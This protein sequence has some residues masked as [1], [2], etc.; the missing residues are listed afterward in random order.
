[1]LVPL[2]TYYIFIQYSSCFFLCCLFC[3]E[4]ASYEHPSNYFTKVLH[5]LF[6][7]LEKMNIFYEKHG[8][9]KK[10]KPCYSNEEKKNHFLHSNRILSNF[11]PSGIPLKMNGNNGYSWGTPVAC[12]R[13]C[14]AYQCYSRFTSCKFILDLKIKQT[15]SVMANQSN[16]D[17]PRKNF[18]HHTCCNSINITEAARIRFGSTL[19]I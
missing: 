4:N 6:R 16:Q 1:M 3:W 7:T 17:F 18:C 12:H 2:P 14:S 9:Y 15:F 11:I 8:F 19:G 5:I 13:I 10:T